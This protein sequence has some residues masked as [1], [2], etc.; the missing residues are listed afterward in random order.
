MMVPISL[1]YKFERNR[2]KEMKPIIQHFFSTRAS[3]LK[4]IRS[5]CT[6]QH[7]DFQVN[8]HPHRLTQEVEVDKCILMKLTFR[9]VNRNSRIRGHI[10]VHLSE[11]L[12]GGKQRK[13]I[14]TDNEPELDLRIASEFY[15][16]FT[17]VMAAV[18]ADPKVAYSHSDSCNTVTKS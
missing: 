8:F 6:E 3:W 11:S 2:A 15:S 9:N 7:I 14:C 4:E 12:P 17:I 18:K 16:W 13:S 1:A 10:F 5:S